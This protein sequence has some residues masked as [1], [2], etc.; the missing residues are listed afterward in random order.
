MKFDWRNNR[1]FL[2][3]LFFIFIGAAAMLISRDYPMGSALRMGPGYFPTVLG[4]IVAVF[5]IYVLI[6]GVIN[7]EKV[8]GNWS[9]RALFVLPVATTIF[10]VMMETVGFVPALIVLMFTSAVAGREFKFLE[11]TI[12]AVVMAVVCTGVFIYGLGLPYP[13]FKGH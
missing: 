13:L 3:G 5:G 10:G 7:N 4:G 12:M 1:D 8:V 9:L 2:S 11:V 6:K